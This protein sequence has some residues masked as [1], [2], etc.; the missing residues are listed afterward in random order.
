MSLQMPEESANEPDAA[1]GKKIFISWHL[2]SVC[3]LKEKMT[4]DYNVVG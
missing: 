2:G 1:V 4:N 3:C